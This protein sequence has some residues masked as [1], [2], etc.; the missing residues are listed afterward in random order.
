MAFDDVPNSDPRGPICPKCNYP[1]LASQPA[2]LVHY[3]QRVER[4]HGECARPL[5]DK[6]TPL[7]K[8]MGWA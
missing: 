7:M 5:W 6:L 3:P 8:R 2:T 1:I 4:W